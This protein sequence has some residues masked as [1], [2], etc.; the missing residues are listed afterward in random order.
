MKITN[1]LIQ[2]MNETTRRHISTT[3]EVEITGV[4]VE[5]LSLT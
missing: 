1:Y 2:V 3:R 5:T 4:P